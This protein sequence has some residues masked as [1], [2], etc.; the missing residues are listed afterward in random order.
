MLRKKIRPGIGFMAILGQFI[1]YRQIAQ[2][3]GVQDLKCVG[4]CDRAQLNFILIL[5]YKFNFSTFNFRLKQ[6]LKIPHL[7]VQAVV[8]DTALNP[9]TVL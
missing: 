4:N 2:R 8:V 1:F 3:F 9:K 5:Y 6:T 7:M